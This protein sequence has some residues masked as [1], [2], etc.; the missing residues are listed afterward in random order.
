MSFVYK[1]YGTQFL[2][3]SV[4]IMGTNICKIRANT[5]CVRVFLQVR[6]YIAYIDGKKYQLVHNSALINIAV[7]TL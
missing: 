1:L 4:T 2:N 3:K 5:E 7:I 6:L